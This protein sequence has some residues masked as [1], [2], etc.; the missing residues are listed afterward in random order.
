MIRLA[1]ISD[2]H[3]SRPLCWPRVNCKQLLGR[4][5]WLCNRRFKHDLNRLNRRITTILTHKPD[6]VILTGDLTQAG[7]VSE[8][9]AAVK[10]LDPLTAAGIPILLT[11]GNHDLYNN[12]PLVADTLIRA[13]TTMRLGLAMDDCGIIR[14]QNTLIVMLQQAQ[15]TPIFTAWGEVGAKPM[16]RLRERLLAEPYSGPRV[17]AGHYPVQDQR[18]AFLSGSCG[19]RDALELLDLFQKCNISA[20]YCGH[21]HQP[22]ERELCTGCIQYCAGSATIKQREGKYLHAVG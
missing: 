14:I 21:L 22:F 16:A 6:L 4:I 7:Q 19:L 18:G 8:I 1:H 5:N 11:V 3:I 13:A 9:E 20:Y 12:T 15:S 2:L 17:I 10:I